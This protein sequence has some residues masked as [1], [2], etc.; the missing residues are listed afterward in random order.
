MRRKRLKELYRERVAVDPA[1]GRESRQYR[2]VGRYSRLMLSAEE[3]RALGRRLIALAAVATLS[4]LCV[5]F[6]NVPS[7]RCFYALPFFLAVPLP[8]FFW[9]LAIL[10]F[11]RIGERM[12]E[13]ERDKGVDA[14]ARSAWGVAILCAAR[15]AGG[16]VFMALG[17]AGDALGSELICEG[18]MLLCGLCALSGARLMRGIPCETLP[19]P[20]GADDV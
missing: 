1:T 3:K 19:D 13:P 7:G 6:Q 18:L 14:Q 10:R 4:Y 16:A 5:G 20:E 17:G 2:Y 11:R 12:T 15:V 9:W 8:L